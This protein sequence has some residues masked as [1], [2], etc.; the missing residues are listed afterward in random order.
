MS[1]PSRRSLRREAEPAVQIGPRLSKP[2]LPS[3]W[4]TAVV[5]DVHLDHVILGAAMRIR[6]SGT[7][8]LGLAAAESSDLQPVFAGFGLPG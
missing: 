3:S 7:L 4:L 2:P 5:A 8:L 1:P 6:R